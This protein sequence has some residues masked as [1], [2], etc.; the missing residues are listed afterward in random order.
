[1]KNSP[2]V[3]A[4]HEVLAE[5][6]NQMEDQKPMCG[7]PRRVGLFTSG[8]P[9]VE[10]H[11]EFTSDQIKRVFSQ[12]RS[13]SQSAVGPEEIQT[14]PCSSGQFV[15]TVLRGQRW[16]SLHGSFSMDM[17]SLVLAD[18]HSKC[19]NLEREKK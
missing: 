15:G 6:L 12:L 11:G 14:R 17:L 8:I 5:S 13:T 10:L 18:L 4:G 16:V 2:T 3:T 7:S 9:R 1:M 19:Q